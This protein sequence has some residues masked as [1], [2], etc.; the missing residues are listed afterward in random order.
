MTFI[1]QKG[2]GGMPVYYG[3]RYQQGRGLEVRVNMFKSFFRFI[4][5]V[6]KTH[7]VPLLKTAADF[8]W[9]RRCC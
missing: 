1:N 5:P 2:A 7:G 8:V 3:A 9:F 4:A 6:V